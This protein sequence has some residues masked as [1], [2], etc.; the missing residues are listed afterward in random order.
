MSHSVIRA[1]KLTE[2]CGNWLRYITF[3]D[4]GGST[5]CQ[6]ILHKTENV[7]VDGKVFYS[8]LQ[9]Y[10]KQMDIPHYRGIL[11]PSNQLTDESK[12][13][14]LVYTHVIQMMYNDLQIM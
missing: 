8:M 1:D 9:E 6:K 7:P 11:C 10:Q 5:L 13:D 4:K 14:I 2:E 3:I 12:F